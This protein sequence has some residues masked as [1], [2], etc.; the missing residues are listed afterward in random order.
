MR[1]QVRCQDMDAVSCWIGG[2]PIVLMSEEVVGGP[3][4]LFNLT[5]ELGHLML[6]P[7]IEVTSSNLD[8]IEKQSN[9]FA[10]LFLLP[11]ETFSRELL[12]SSIAYF[13]A[14]KARW[15]MSIA[16]MACRSR[17][18][19][20]LSEN[21]FSYLVRQMNS[22][23]IRKVEPLDDAFPVNRPTMLAEG[24]RMLVEHG[25]YTRA[26]IEAALGLNLRDV[27]GPAGLAE[28][29]LDQRVVP[30]KLRV[31]FASAKASGR[32]LG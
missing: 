12:D 4:D 16:S 6:H 8:M 5:H 18:F 24:L 1:E 9:R 29:Y 13:K 25:V 10:S 17:D 2:R 28:G 19:G 32:D 23:G 15:G 20:I 31:D 27:E 3:R 22:L 30:M 14:S 21:Q 26:Q 7:D 11:R